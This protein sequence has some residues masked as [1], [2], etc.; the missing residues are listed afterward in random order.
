M[1]PVVIKDYVKPP[2]TIKRIN[3]EKSIY[4]AAA[5]PG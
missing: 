4:K 1:F 3:P 2:T 5:L